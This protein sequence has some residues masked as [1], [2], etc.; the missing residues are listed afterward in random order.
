M[1]KTKKGFKVPHVYVIVIALI[2]LSAIL[3]Y[4]NPRRHLRLSV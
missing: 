4:I 2:L 3:T 1:T